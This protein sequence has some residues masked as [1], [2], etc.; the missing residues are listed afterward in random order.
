MLY[1]CEQWMG[2]VIPEEDLTAGKLG[3]YLKPEDYSPIKQVSNFSSTLL[4]VL[5]VA[6]LFP[7]SARLPLSSP[8]PPVPPLPPDLP[9]HSLYPKNF[10]FQKHVCTRQRSNN[11]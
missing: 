4:L 8:H 7:G 1:R 9:V 2:K 11:N 10:K 3:Q 5:M 6:G